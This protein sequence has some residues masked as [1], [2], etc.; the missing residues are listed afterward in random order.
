M[1]R[2]LKV[3]VIMEVLVC[4]GPAAALLLLGVVVA[5]MQVYFLVTG[6]R[7]AV[8]GALYV[9]GSVIAGLVGL[10]V[11][12]YVLRRL[13]TGTPINRPIVVVA[14]TLAALAPLSFYVMFADTVGYRIM[15]A[16]PF[17]A[18][19]HILYLSRRL[20]ATSKVVTGEP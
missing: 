18:A 16:L 13:F 1:S 9:I 7:E 2:W 14:A 17:A 5:P 3:L 20:F 8:P 10:G 15:A 6:P 19:A 12:T 11:M 4:F